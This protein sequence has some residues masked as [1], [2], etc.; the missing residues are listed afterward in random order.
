MC[1]KN[2]KWRT[3]FS[4]EAVSLENLYQLHGT[5]L[6]VAQILMSVTL[7]IWE[8]MIVSYN[9][10]WNITCSLW[11]CHQQLNM[12]FWIDSYCFIDSL[13]P[14]IGSFGLGEASRFRAS[15][16]LAT[17]FLIQLACPWHF[18]R[19]RLLFVPLISFLF[20]SLDP[21]G[22]LVSHLFVCSVWSGALCPG[23]GASS[24]VPYYAFV[25]E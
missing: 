20:C 15:Q 1:Q 3:F 12:I 23:W 24:L 7:L 11:V 13:T 8:L 25:I 22:E 10:F 17:F 5:I 21:V 6:T 14:E 19:M 16:A 18:I 4:V 2:V 9:I